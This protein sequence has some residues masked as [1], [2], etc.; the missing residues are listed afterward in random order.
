[1]FPQ[2]AN[3]H[4]RRLLFNRLRV[5]LSFGILFLFLRIFSASFFSHDILL[6]LVGWDTQILNMLT[7]N[8]F[9]K[10]YFVSIFKF[11]CYFQPVD[12]SFLANENVERKLGKGD[13]QCSRG[14]NLYQFS[15]LEF[16]QIKIQSLYSD[17]RPLVKNLN[18][19]FRILI[20]FAHPQEGRLDVESQDVVHSIQA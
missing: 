3:V 18:L 7:T 17:P 15:R 14:V 8:V 2:R 12:R 5:I 1:M 16:L 19:W 13:P 10:M 6:S 4:Q 9:I 20:L 11:K